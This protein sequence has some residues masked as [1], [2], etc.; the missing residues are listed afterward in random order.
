MTE[1]MCDSEG[2]KQ[3]TMWRWVL[4]IVLCLPVFTRAETLVFSE[5]GYIK[6]LGPVEDQPLYD[7]IGK[8]LARIGYDFEVR[9]EPRKRAVHESLSGKTDGLLFQTEKVQEVHPSLIRVDYELFDASIYLYSIQEPKAYDI[10]KQ[11]LGMMLGYDDF[12]SQLARIFGCDN[13]MQSYYGHQLQQMINM[14]R[15]DR[16]DWVLMPEALEPYLN[17]DRETPLYRL[18]ES[19]ITVPIY[20]Y[21]NEHNKHLAK[22]IAN[23]LKQTYEEQG[24]TSKN[25]HLLLNRDGN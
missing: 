10:C 9:F 6:H 3:I 8:A 7:I 1:N 21:L 2:E 24:I 5:Y 16:L 22:P 19:K 13:P 23:A 4:I 15:G 18:K 12:S 25:V 14:M 20:M 17:S 11:R